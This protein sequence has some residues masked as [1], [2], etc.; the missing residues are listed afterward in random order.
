MRLKIILTGCLLA[1]L[2][3]VTLSAEKKNKG[4]DAGFREQY[5]S[6]KRAL[7][8]TSRVKGSPDPPSPFRTQVAFPNLKFEQPLELTSA[9]GTNRL[10]V[11][12]RF[13]KIFSFSEN[14]RIAAAAELLI[15]LKKTIYGLAFHPNFQENGY[16]YVTYVLDPIE[17]NPKGTRLSRF[18][19]RSGT[20]L[21][22]DTNS[23]KIILEWLSGGHNGGCLR[24]GPDG[25]LYIVT[26]DGSGFSDA[27]NTGQDITDLLASILRIDVDR[28]NSGRHYGIPLDNPF[29][30]NKKARP[31]IWAYGLRQVWKMN[32]DRKTGN[33]WAGE[34]GQDLWEM[35]NLILPGGNYGWS[36]KEGMHPFRPERKVGPTPILEPIVEH[37]HTDFRSITGGFVYRGSRLPELSDTYVYGD[38]DTGRIWGFRYEDHQVTSHRELVDTSFR[39]IDFGET[40]DGELYLLDFIGGQIHQL[41]PAPILEKTAPF[42]LRLSDTGLFASVSEHKPAKGLIPY[43]VNSQLWSDGAIKERWIALPGNSQIDFDTVEY[44]APA[45]GAPKGWRFPDGTVIVKTFSLDLELGD[46][47]S[48]HRVETRLLHHEALGGDE[49]AN[50]VGD[51]YWKGYSY[52]WNEDQTD[53][54]LVKAEGL[55]RKYTI[56]DTDAPNERRDQVWHFPS[57][58]ECTLCHTTAAKY[59]LGLHTLQMNKLN[60]YGWVV[61]NQLDLLHRLG[62]FSEP[63]PS[64]PAELPRI[65]DHLDQNR[66]LDDRARAYLHSNCAHCHRKWGGGNADFQL[67]APLSLEQ[68]KILNA[69]PAHGDFDIVG[70]QLLAPGSPDRSLILYRMMKLGLGRMPHV[71]S[72][73]VDKEAAKLIQSWISSLPNEVANK[74]KLP[75]N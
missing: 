5:G 53:A 58:A 29:V 11:V 41:V 65:Y 32:F 43:S 19:V 52:A 36:V 48:R 47:S 18:Q 64:P 39:I 40:N 69:P 6:L 56:V 4:K 50:E 31:E 8:T 14:P 3:Y 67:L 60:D 2:G 26:G 59:V 37:S 9:P 25:Y 7:W 38:Y 27:R 35:I 23:E 21:R 66:S 51:Q 57:R 28:S 20:S 71:A 12:E 22:A 72:N 24:F 16:F 34:V 62:V 49:L 70:G 68:T 30:K 10:F 73:V 42:P 1:T 45:P 54:F 75:L 61:A 13:G 46:P 15:D 17:T 63:L 55:D 74:R 44:P 33:L